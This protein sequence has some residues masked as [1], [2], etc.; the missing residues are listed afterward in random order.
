MTVV[1]ANM[2]GYVEATIY[3]LFCSTWLVW[4]QLLVVY[5]CAAL[6]AHVPVVLGYYA[7]SCTIISYVP[8]LLYPVT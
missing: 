7:W 3:H 2:V 6:L 8:T 4:Q 5:A 1:E